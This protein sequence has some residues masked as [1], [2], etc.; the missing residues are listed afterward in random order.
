M[1]RKLAETK[2]RHLF[3][4]RDSRILESIGMG[5]YMTAEALEWLHFP[6]WRD[7]W[8]AYVAGGKQGYYKPCANLY[9]RLAYL[10]RQGLI[11]QV[12]R[13]V[14]NA[15]TT[16]GRDANLYMLTSFGAEE[17]AAGY[18]YDR[19]DLGATRLRPK[20]L[21]T[22]SHAAA[23]ARFYA[24]IRTKLE[25]A[26]SLRLAEWR[27]EH[28]TAREYDSVTIIPLSREKPELVK[29]AIQ[30]DGVLMLAQGEHLDPHYLAFVEI[31]RGTRPIRT[32]LEKIQ[33]YH[34]Y[35]TDEKDHVLFQRRF[36]G[37]DNFTV[38][39]VVPTMARMQALA[40]GVVAATRPV[41]GK[42][43]EGWYVNYNF[44]LEEHVHPLTIG[45]HWKKIDK[46][47]RGGQHRLRP[48]IELADW[49]FV[50]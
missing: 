36:S 43:A 32:W 16:F 33:G 19:Q 46:A 6:T 7:R 27:G 5:R 45:S 49:T 34:A 23:G 9:T 13:T 17:V 26:Q 22:L 35:M 14:Q 48:L 37:I 8:A 39:T 24:A 4:W 21:H 20:S 15:S 25:T 42:V 41:P 40:Q 2:A 11:H 3:T 47:K 1:P 10:Q 12:V 50:R 38:L 29:Q 44:I 28:V 30:P 18:G 31:D